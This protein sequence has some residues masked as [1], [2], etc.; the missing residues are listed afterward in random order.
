MIPQSWATILCMTFLFFQSNSDWLFI[1]LKAKTAVNVWHEYVVA[2]QPTMASCDQW[3]GWMIAYILMCLRASF[4]YLHPFR[5]VPIL[6]CYIYFFFLLFWRRLISRGMDIYLFWYPCTYHSFY[7]VQT[8]SFA[9]FCLSSWI[10]RAFFFFFFWLW[11]RHDMC[12]FASVSFIVCLSGS[13][14]I[15]HILA[16]LI[17]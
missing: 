17:L 16:F 7:L 6:L 11:S 15:D 2:S 1:Y 3:L 9:Y 14:M 8:L 5:I 12:Y 10:L 13:I 4:I